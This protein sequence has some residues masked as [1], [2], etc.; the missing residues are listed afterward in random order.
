MSYTTKQN[1][2]YLLSELHLRYQTLVGT[3][4]ARTPIDAFDGAGRGR[5]ATPEKVKILNKSAAERNLA[6]GDFKTILAE[7]QK[8]K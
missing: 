7:I 5:W 6:V 8:L 2:E 3:L 4:D 1:L